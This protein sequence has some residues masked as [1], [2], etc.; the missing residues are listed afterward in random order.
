MTRTDA[1]CGAVAA[2]DN[3]IGFHKWDD[4]PREQGVKHFCGPEKRRCGQP[5]LRH[6]VV[7]RIERFGADHANAFALFRIKDD[8][9][10]HCVDA[11]RTRNHAPIDI[12]AKQHKVRKSPQH[13]GALKDGRFHHVTRLAPFRVVIDE[14]EPVLLLCRG[15]RVFPVRSPDDRLGIRAGFNCRDCE[16]QTK[17]SSAHC[18]HGKS[19]AGHSALAPWRIQKLA[20][21][22]YQ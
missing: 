12:N 4:P 1:K 8:V 9:S 19:V 16:T 13:F 21:A 11:M 5:D 18:D 2:I 22:G 10:R 14:N 7:E 17:E 15:K 6:R 20:L 3:C